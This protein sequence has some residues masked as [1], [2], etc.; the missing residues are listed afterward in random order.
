[1]NLKHDDLFRLDDGITV[2]WIVKLENLAELGNPIEDRVLRELRRQRIQG[3]VVRL[4]FFFG[5]KEIY[6]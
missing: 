6:A 5:N 4:F 3:N 2:G 1:M